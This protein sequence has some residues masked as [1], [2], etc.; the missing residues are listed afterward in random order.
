MEITKNI[1]GYDSPDD[2]TAYLIVRI[3]NLHQRKLNAELSSLDLTYT[4]YIL[5]S[6]IYWLVYKKYEVT[7]VLLADY[8]KFDKSTV[9]SVLKT[10][11]SKKLITRK[12]HPVDT[13]AKILNITSKGISLLED[14][15]IIV[16]NVDQIVFENNEAD[17]SCVNKKLHNILSIYNDLF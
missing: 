16:N 15:S 13:R 6:G 5:L 4:Q 8:V 2:S 9:S 1:F 14:A 12:E 10:L 7:Q 17:I 3:S 11:I